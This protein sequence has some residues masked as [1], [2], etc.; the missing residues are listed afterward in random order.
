MND[1]ADI[2]ADVKRRGITRLCHFMQSRKLSHVL[3]QTQALLPTKQLYDRYR[4]LLDVTDNVRLDRHLDHVCCSIEYP[5]SWYLHQIHDRDPLFKDR[6]IVCLNPALVWERETL[7]C[8]R[9]AAAQGGALIQTGWRGWQALFVPQ[10]PGSYGRTRIRTP[11]RLDCCPTDD[12]AEALV[13]DA[14]PQ[15]YIRAVVVKD[16]QQAH[17]EQTRLQVLGVQPLF[18]WIVAADLFTTHWSSLVRHGK[19]PD[20]RLF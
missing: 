7:F 15:H 12:Q 20:E 3:T 13:P 6:V 18:S 1:Y 16:A 17:R 4:D 9:N 8:P 5:N 11:Q 19:R 2:Q 14:I 10:V